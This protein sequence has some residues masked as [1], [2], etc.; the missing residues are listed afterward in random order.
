MR[1]PCSKW[2]IRPVRSTS[3]LRALFVCL[4][5]SFAIGSA[6]A[7]EILLNCHGKWVDVRSKLEKPHVENIA[8]APDDVVTLPWASDPQLRRAMSIPIGDRS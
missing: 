1:P 5:L 2:T 6:E 3:G 7:N 4:A 8:I